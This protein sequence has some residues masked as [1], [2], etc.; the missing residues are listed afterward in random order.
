MENVKTYAWRMVLTGAVLHFLVDGLCLCCL[1]LLASSWRLTDTAEICMFVTYNVMAFLTQPLTGA[2]ADRMRQKH[3]MLL[4]AM[5]LLTAAVACTSLVAGTGLLDDCQ[6]SIVNC[7]QSITSTIIATLLGL[8]NSLFHVWGGK[9]TALKTGNDI[10]ALGVFVSTGVM[11]LA[12]SSMLYSWGLL[13]G[14]LLAFCI[15]A[16]LTGRFDAEEVC[17]G[18]EEERKAKVGERVTWWTVVCMAVLMGVVMLRSYMGESM[19]M[20]TEKC[21]SG[22]DSVELKVLLVGAAA[23]LGKMMGG[24]LVRGMGM[25]KAIA[26][27]VVITMVCLWGRNWNRD[28]ML[29]GL[30][31]VNCTMPMTLYLANKVLKGREGLAFGWLAAALMPGYLMAT[32]SEGEMLRLLM[33][34]LVPTVLIEGGVLWMLGE[35]RKKVLGAS[36]VVNVLTNVPLNLWVL[37]VDGSS[38]SILTGEFLVVMVETMWYFMFVKRLKVAFI[39]SLL[40]NAISFLTG[41]FIQWMLILQP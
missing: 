40:C 16:A 30:W 22:I 20:G 27:V 28:T 2:W 18:D 31:A 38:V 26:A 9:Q 24:W 10:R 36:V 25:V 14:F 8:G 39:Y 4:G 5:V 17:A 32:S 23:M 35:R 21:C 3:W 34:A 12:V 41:L 1:W 6:S 19:Q 13:F 37:C 7:Q 33:T 15:L 29:A 11:G